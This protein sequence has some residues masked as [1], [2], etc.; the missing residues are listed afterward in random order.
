MREIFETPAG[1]PISENPMEAA[2]R[3][4]RPVL[5]RRFYE[6]ATVTGTPNG[7]AVQLDGK[8]VH[9]P[10]RR[11]LAAPSRAS[12]EALAA[13]WNAQTEFVDPAKMPLTRLANAII[14]GVA[15]TS[16]AV[17]DE[18]KKYLATDLLFYRAGAPQGLVEQQAKHWDPILQ[19]AAEILGAKFYLGEGVIHVE[20]PEGALAAAIAAIPDDP[21]QLG[22]AH[23]ITT[24]TGSALIALAMA[25]GQ[26]SSEAAW[27]AAHVDEDW[28]MEQ[29]GRDEMAMQRRDFR[30]GE[31]QAAAAVLKA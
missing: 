10:A 4:A 24:L 13:E 27:Q 5:R 8:P 31:F 11:L 16:Q 22:A 25:R 17:A 3:G 7:F 21:W 15:D 2:R 30:F 28:N 26:L 14:D 6:N 12:G 19:W 1:N 23:V 29:W 20:Q 18:I 9:T